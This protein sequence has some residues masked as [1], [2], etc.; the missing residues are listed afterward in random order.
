MNCLLQ[1]LKNRKTDTIAYINDFSP[2]TICITVTFKLP[3]LC[4]KS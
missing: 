4:E 1:I 3:L 2:K